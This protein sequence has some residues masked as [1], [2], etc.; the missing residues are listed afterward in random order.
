MPPRTATSVALLVL[1]LACGG[2]VAA[3]EQARLTINDDV[4]NVP[5]GKPFA[6]RIDGKKMTLR[7]DPQTDLVFNE[8]GV[9]F[10]YPKALGAIDDAGGEGVTVWTLQGQNVALMLQLY[11]EGLDAKSLLEV[12]VGNLIEREGEENV[13]RQDVKLTGPQ[14][15]YQGV[16]LQIASP[17]R[18]NQPATKSVQNVFTFANKQGVF[19]M[20]LQDV[21]VPGGEDS[22]EYNDTLR[23]LGESLKTGQPPKGSAAKPPAAQ[24]RRG[25]AKQ[26]R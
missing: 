22:G 2:S 26:K 15:A 4:Y 11:E 5:L 3:Q 8:G 24:P 17:A 25:G 7:I 14:R 23:L 20:I 19:A 13:K 6:V 18:D 9:S 1:A 16:Q 21:R 12:L 10:R